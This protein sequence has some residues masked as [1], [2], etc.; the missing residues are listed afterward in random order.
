MNKIN[1]LLV[2][3]LIRVSPPFLLCSPGLLRR[4]T[5]APVLSPEISRTV[6]AEAEDTTLTQEAQQVSSRKLS[7]IFY[8]V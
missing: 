5:S 4:K 1:I 2:G 7:Y 6:R 8:Q 3:V